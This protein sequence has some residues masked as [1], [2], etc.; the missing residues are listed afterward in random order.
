LLDQIKLQWAR[1]G[2]IGMFKFMQLFCLYR[3]LLFVG[4]C[5][6]MW[7]INIHLFISIQPFSVTLLGKFRS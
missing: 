2:H 7:K 4:D 6:F 3:L 1:L 5:F